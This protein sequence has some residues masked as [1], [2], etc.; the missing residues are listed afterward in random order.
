MKHLSENLNATQ[1][2]AFLDLSS[3]CHESGAPNEGRPAFTDHY[4]LLSVLKFLEQEWFMFSVWKLGLLTGQEQ[5]PYKIS[6]RPCWKSL[7]F[8]L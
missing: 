4:F 8:L 7:Y 3:E 6:L 5:T 1:L 2:M